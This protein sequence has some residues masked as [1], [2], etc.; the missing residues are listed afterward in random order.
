MTKKRVLDVGNCSPDHNSIRTMLQ[1][2]FDVEVL[3]ADNANDALPM[4]R[5]EKVDLVLVNRKL[6]C[7]YSDGIDII[8]AIKNDPELKSIPAMLVT[9]MDEHQQDAVSK[10]AEYG[11][12][13]LALRTPETQQRLQQFLA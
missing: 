8:V 10:G 12:G 13:K 7:D 4:L 3:Q 9:N 5:R 11:F 1:Q 2:N 6:D